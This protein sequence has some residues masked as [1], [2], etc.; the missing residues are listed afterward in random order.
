MLHF[1][2]VNHN[3]PVNDLQDSSGMKDLEITIYRELKFHD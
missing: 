3:I 2:R 1:G